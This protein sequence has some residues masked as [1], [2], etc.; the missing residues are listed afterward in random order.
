M[1]VTVVLAFFGAS[2]GFDDRINPL[3]PGPSKLLQVGVT[4]L[5]FPAFEAEKYVQFP[6]NGP[7]WIVFAANSGI[8]TLMLY[9]ALR[10]RRLRAAT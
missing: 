10:W 2:V 9:F 6:N 3:P 8:W 4:V 5:T 1:S 7:W